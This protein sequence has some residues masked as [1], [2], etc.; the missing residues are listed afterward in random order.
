MSSSTC[1]MHLT[2]GIQWLNLKSDAHL[3][4]RV[5]NYREFHNLLLRRHSRDLLNKSLVT[6]AFS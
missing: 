4:V 5:E 2:N 3:K 1:N 6:I